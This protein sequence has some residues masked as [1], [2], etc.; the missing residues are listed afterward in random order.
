MLRLSLM[1]VGS[2]VMWVVSL[3]GWIGLMAT[4]A[5]DPMSWAAVR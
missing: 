1:A 4:A 5:W 2:G 3:S